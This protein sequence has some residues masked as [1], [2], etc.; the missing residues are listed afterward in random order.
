MVIYNVIFIL[1]IKTILNKESECPIIECNIDK[2]IK[3]DTCLIYNPKENK[4]VFLK[5]CDNVNY[6]CPLQSDEFE[7]GI[8]KC[9]KKK[10]EKKKNFP[11]RNCNNDDECISGD[12]ND[13]DECNGKKINEYCIDTADC[14]KSFSCINNTC[15]EHRKINEYCTQDTDC[16]LNAGC[17]KNKC[18][19]YFSLKDGEKIDQKT[20]FNDGLSFCEKGVAYNGICMDL[21]LL[22]QKSP[23]D[24][25]NPCRYEHKINNSYSENITIKENCLCGY[26]GKKY[27]RLGGLNLNYSNYIN[28]KKQYLSNNDCHPAEHGINDICDKENNNLKLENLEIWALYNY[29]MYNAKNCILKMAF[30]NYNSVYDRKELQ[31]DNCRR[32]ICNNSISNPHICFHKIVKNDES[33]D[34]NL[35]YNNSIKDNLKNVACE[36]KGRSGDIA[37]TNEYQFNYNYIEINYLAGDYCNQT[38]GNNEKLKCDNNKCVFKNRTNK[39]CENHVDCDV[40]EYCEIDAVQGKRCEL[41]KD[42]DTSCMSSYECKNYLICIRS[43]CQDT[44]YKIPPGEESDNDYACKYGKKINGR[45]VKKLYNK[46]KGKNDSEYY[47]D[48]EDFVRCDKECMYDYI[49]NESYIEGQAKITNN[50][51]CYCGYRNNGVKYCSLDDDSFPDL[52]ERYHFLHIQL[53]NDT[54][55]TKNRYNCSH[56]PYFNKEIYEEYISLKIFFENG[57][58]FYK[59]EDCVEYV[60]NGFYYIFN[61]LFLLFFYL[62]VF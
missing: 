8:L 19:E 43:I 48:Y 54:C 10:N 23:C 62:I 61:K 15:Q 14:L 1:L 39:F 4:T 42:K 55:H 41:L 30:P 53:I 9:I 52:I 44:L 20:F 60:M 7:E 58:F 18:I 25:N 29:K 6:Y 49:F 50:D 37:D 51:G 32:Y 57:H 31:Q 24:D 11:E 21:K 16:E 36:G 17:H 22:N 12:C 26:D 28:A 59:S 35:N 33:V 40:G 56:W 5:V 46:N 2:K 34:I 3:N 27:C 45:C 47:K 38:C 13:D